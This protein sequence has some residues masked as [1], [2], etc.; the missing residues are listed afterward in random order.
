MDEPI[1]IPQSPNGVEPLI[2][3]H[4]ELYSGFTLE[5]AGQVFANIAGA[6]NRMIGVGMATGEVTA[7]NPITQQVFGASNALEQAFGMI[8]QALQ[9]RRE[10]SGIVTAMPIPPRGPIRM[11]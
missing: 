7:A 8:Q 2:Q 4:V 11:H 3:L 6:L 1:Q 5:Q 10:Q 9:Q